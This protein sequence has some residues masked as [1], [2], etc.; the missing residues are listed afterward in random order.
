[1]AFVE[2]GT[3]KHYA[4]REFVFVEG[5]PSTAAYAVKQGI[6]GTTTIGADGRETFNTLRHS[7]DVFG[8][9]ELILRRARTRNAVVM[10]AGELLVIERERFV[11]LLSA[12]P[13]ILLAMLGSAYSRWTTLHHMRADLAGGSA[14]RRVA[15]TLRY[16]AESRAEV[17]ADSDEAP[18]RITHET[19]GNLCDL[20]RQTVTTI[21]A[22]FEALGLVELGFRSL[23]LLDLRRLAAVIESDDR[24]ELSV[25]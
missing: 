2:W 10:D 5:E 22:E 24:A 17:A 7:G 13:D 18:L 20:S 8:F 14:R 15:S 6:V 16:L 21:L 11:E 1:L 23:R 19:I 12:R 9:S 4:R 3:P 25:G